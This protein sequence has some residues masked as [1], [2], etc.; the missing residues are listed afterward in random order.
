MAE[1][2][3]I[4]VFQFRD[5]ELGESLPQLDAPLVKGIDVPDCALGKDAVLME[6][7]QFAQCVRRQPL[8]KDCGG[9]PVALEN[10]VGCQPHRNALGQNFMGLPLCPFP[11]PL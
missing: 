7:D 3:F 8:G 2:G 11:E 9:R 4:P 5:D 10:L 1:Q 6:G